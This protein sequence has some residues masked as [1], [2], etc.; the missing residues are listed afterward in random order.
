MA[1]KMKF[2]TVQEVADK[3]GVSK[4][5]IYNWVKQGMIKLTHLSEGTTRISETDL[6]DFIRGRTGDEEEGVT[7]S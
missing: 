7:S 6:D 4:P 3:F 5:T 2:F 1:D